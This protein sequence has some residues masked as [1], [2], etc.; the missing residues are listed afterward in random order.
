MHVFLFPIRSKGTCSASVKEPRRIALPQTKWL[1]PILV[2][3]MFCRSVS[4]EE[5]DMTPLTDRLMIRGGC[6]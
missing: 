1:L 5:T 6:L 3:A 4:A 2:L